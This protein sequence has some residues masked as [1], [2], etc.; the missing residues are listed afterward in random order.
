MRN[1]LSIIPYRVFRSSI[2]AEVDVSALGE[3]SQNEAEPA[4]LAP[5]S[6][7]CS[8]LLLNDDAAEQ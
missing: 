4:S 7:G 1:S 6:S 5:T 8:S 2:P 3:H